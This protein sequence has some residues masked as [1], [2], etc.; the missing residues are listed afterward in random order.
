MVQPNLQQF[1]T[2]WAASDWPTAFSQPFREPRLTPCDAGNGKSW[3][4]CCNSILRPFQTAT[5][6]SAAMSQ[7]SPTGFAFGI[8]IEIAA[9]VGIVSLLPRFDLRPANSAAADQTPP[10]APDS[11]VTPIGW[12]EPARENVAA[13]PT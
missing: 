13:R 2:L 3:H 9:V 4:R 12:S 5:K 1:C 6:E 8:L 10:P 7:Q 11:S